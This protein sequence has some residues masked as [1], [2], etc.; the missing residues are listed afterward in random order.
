MTDNTYR[1][2]SMGALLKDAFQALIR[3]IDT[4]VNVPSMILVCSGD[5]VRFVNWKR[6]RAECHD[7]AH[8]TEQTYFEAERMNVSRLFTTS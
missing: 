6:T 7:Y 3:A 1:H 2:L 4:C 8:M 5:Y